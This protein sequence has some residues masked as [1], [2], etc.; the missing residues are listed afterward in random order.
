[1]F[2]RFPLQESIGIT[3]TIP[4]NFE[5]GRILHCKSEIRNLRLDG[6]NLHLE[7]LQLPIDGPIEN[8][9]IT[10]LERLP[11]RGLGWIDIHLLV[12]ASLS[13]VLAGGAA[14]RSTILTP[15][16]VGL[17]LD[18]TGRASLQRKQRA[19]LPAPRLRYLRPEALMMSI[20]V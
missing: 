16:N 20:R 2:R 13:R 4:G 10:R 12:S 5:I 6:S 8:I 11:S 15:A 7:H 14:Q 18:E 9:E 3:P 17:T 19:S 1:M